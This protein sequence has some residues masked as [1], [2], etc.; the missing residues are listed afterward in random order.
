M[1][2]LTGGEPEH[3]KI[4]LTMENDRDAIRVAIES[5][6]LIPAKEMKIIRIK[7][8]LQLSELDVSTAYIEKLSGHSNLEVVSGPEA[9]RFN[10]AGNLL[11]TIGQVF[12]MIS[13]VS[14]IWRELNAFPSLNTIHSVPAPAQTGDKRCQ[15]PHSDPK[16]GCPNA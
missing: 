8:T 6:G 3:A 16:A 4:P 14:D 15:I 9:M 5:V 7:N 12:A 10:D 2:A 11:D 13:P 1:N